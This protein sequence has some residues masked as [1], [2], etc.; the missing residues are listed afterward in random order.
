MIRHCPKATWGGK[1]LLQVALPQYRPSLRKI[2]AG[3]Q[4][5]QGPGAGA[6]AGG[7]K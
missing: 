4:T 6:D 2:M 7:I 5:W 3:I 1:G